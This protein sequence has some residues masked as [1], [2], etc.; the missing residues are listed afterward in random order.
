MS[1]SLDLL[2][3]LEPAVRPGG[4]GA[5]AGAP[6]RVPFEEQ[7]FESLLQEMQG[8]SGERGTTPGMAGTAGIRGADESLSAEPDETTGGAGTP[9]VNLLSPLSDLDAISNASL[10]DLIT[11]NHQTGLAEGRHNGTQL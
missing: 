7:S 10:R 8:V 9:R 1:N 3:M 6:Q 4:A 5:P 2:R 11:R